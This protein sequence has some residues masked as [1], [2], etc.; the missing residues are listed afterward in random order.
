VSLQG[1]LD[2]FALPD[3]LALLASTT[4]SGELYVAGHRSAGPG[5]A[6]LQGRLWFDAGRIVGNDVL[7]SAEPA[8]AVF[9]L[10]RLV[11]GTFSFAPGSPPEPGAPVAV[12]PVLTEALARL[13]EW[14]EIEKVVPSLAAWLELTPEVPNGH[15][16]LRSDQWRLVVAVA[17]GRTVDSV[18]RHLELGELAGCR[19]VKEM[20][21]AGLLSLRSDQHAPLATDQWQP[22]VQEPAAWPEP[23]PAPQAEATWE[24]PAEEPTPTVESQLAAV[25]GEAPAWRPELGE[26]PDLDALVTIPPRR[27]RRTEVAE[28]TPAAEP[29]QEATDVEPAAVATA[30]EL[31]EGMDGEFEDGDEPLNRGLL[32]KFLS[33][34][35]N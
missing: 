34:V 1:S 2:T 17:G 15:V 8:D 22:T 28:E 20:V 12:E 21:E 3:V 35:R 24:Q 6:Q 7:D 11:E 25:D 10:L 30:E 19:A 9:E 27:R 26:V 23:A 29:E 4:K 31:P 33:S 32:L 18:L 13:A 14:R 5:V 16:T